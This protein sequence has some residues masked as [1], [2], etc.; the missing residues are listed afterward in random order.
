[1][2]QGFYY[3]DLFEA[4]LF[5]Y[6]SFQR[7]YWELSR[8]VDQIVMFC[9]ECCV[10]IHLELEAH[11]AWNLIGTL[12]L[13]NVK[14]CIELDSRAFEDIF[15]K[16]PVPVCFCPI[17]QNVIQVAWVVHGHDCIL[18]TV[19]CSWTVSL[20]LHVSNT[21]PFTLTLP[22]WIGTNVACF[23][24]LQ[25]PSVHSSSLERGW[26]EKSRHCGQ[27]EWKSD[28]ELGFFMNKCRWFLFNASS[29]FF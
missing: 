22:F 12:S 14:N 19:L 13:L 24:L 4:P 21:V 27:T 20:Y 9:C 1:M 8:S 3:P 7:K 29:E 2:L 26:I 11:C 6:R 16:L 25:L 15:F 5:V 17:L 18:V 23:L 10:Y 28:S